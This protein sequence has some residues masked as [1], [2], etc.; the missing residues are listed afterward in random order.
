MP[1]IPSK[2]PPPPRVPASLGP[3]PAPPPPL[4]P[5]C[6]SPDRD[7]GFSR[8]HDVHATQAAPTGSASGQLRARPSRRIPEP[9][10]E[11][12]SSARRRTPAGPDGAHN[13]KTRKSTANR[14]NPGRHYKELCLPPYG[15]TLYP[16]IV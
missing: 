15:I 3:S 4:P 9:C 13:I 16:P 6:S 5:G 11:S 8:C 14:S 7:Y 2:P 1:S 10:W 12:D